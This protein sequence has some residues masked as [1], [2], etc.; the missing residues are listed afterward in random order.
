MISL[1]FRNRLLFDTPYQKNISVAPLMPIKT[2]NYIQIQETWIIQPFIFYA[3]IIYL[4]THKFKI[5]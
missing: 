2:Y 1:I 5:S 4:A 3:L